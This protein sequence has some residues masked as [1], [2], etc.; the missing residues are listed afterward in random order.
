[1]QLRALLAGIAVGTLLCCTNLY[2]GLQSA[3]ITMASMQAAL[4]GFGLMRSFPKIKQQGRGVGRHHYTQPNGEQQQEAEDEGRTRWGLRTS[5]KPFTAQENVVLQAT[6]VALG[7]MPL[8]A[9]L[10]G[11]VPAFNLLSPSKDGADVH[12][13]S[14]SWPALLIWCAS[15]AL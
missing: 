15:M 2:L 10:I 14:M 4:V 13:F 6:A 1:M 7:A 11:I 9:G 5:F 12:A 3:F 8:S